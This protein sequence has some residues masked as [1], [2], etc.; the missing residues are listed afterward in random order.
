MVL[1]FSHILTSRQEKE[2][3]RVLGVEKFIP[4]PLE[5]QQLWQAIPPL[6]DRITD[7]LIPIR[8]W[9]GSGVA[10]Q[11]D[12][13]LI[14]GDPGATFLLVT[15]AFDLGFIP[16]YST[17]DRQVHEEV[18]GDGRVLIQRSFFHETYRYY[19]RGE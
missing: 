9:L 7:Y 8:S 15:W 12:Y 4:L 2:A 1:C 5:L 11:G 14:Q 3:H 10:N 6:L 16:L 17:T 13:I 18:D 19:E